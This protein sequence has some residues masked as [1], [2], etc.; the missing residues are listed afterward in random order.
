MRF[1]NPLSCLL[2]FCFAATLA[3]AKNPPRHELTPL[4]PEQSQLLSQAMVH[5]LALIATIQEHTPLVETYI[6]KTRPDPKLREVPISDTYMLNRVDFKKDFFDRNYTPRQEGKPSLL[7]Q[8][9]EAFLRASESALMTITRELHLDVNFT[10]SPLGFTE[11]MFFDPSEPNLSRYNF[12]YVR[13]EFLGSVRTVV[14]DVQP[15]N[16][17][18]GGFSGRIWIE[19]QDANIVRLNGTFAPAHEEDSSHH[20]LHFD[21]WRTNV[22][23]GVWLPAAI[24]VEET[25][26]SGGH[27]QIGLKAQ[28]HFWGFSL[29]EPAHSGESVTMTVDDAVD[30]SGDTGDVAPLEA[31]RHW[32]LQAEN[33]VVDR[34]VKAGLVAPITEGGYEQKV[35]DQIVTNLAVP[36]NLT[37]TEPVRC[38]VML[39]TTVEATTAGNTILI[40]KGALDALPNEESIASLVALELAHIELGH[41]IDTRYAFNDRLLFPDEASFQR[42]D[43]YHNDRDNEAAAKRA[44][45]YLKASM[46]AGQL[47][48]AGLFWEQLADRGSMLKNLNTPRLG[49]SLLRPD[50]TPW[51]S[52]L[53]S[54]APKIDW[55]DLA[56][57]PALPLGS[58][59][60][61]DAWDDTVRMIN[62]KRYAPMNPGEKMPLEL[63]PVYYN[64]QRQEAPIQ[65][66]GNPLPPAVDNLDPTKTRAATQ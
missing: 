51:M 26:Y 7:K 56:Q 60:R 11:M 21:S 54:T 14:F 23:P 41:H 61:V 45:D 48:N 65:Q 40:S 52:E 20:I 42:I 9:R 3:Q 31:A 64:L 12:R 39:M 10:E 63:T 33:N 4:T 50:G 53:A 1:R 30:H 6:Q 66:A 5:E 27:D 25:H 2:P 62:A 32:V 15:K 24:Y 19:D 55:D 59:L 8:G 37:F 58:W 18:A 49:D 43:M 36:S 38:R 57:T 17:H 13:R 28:T 16:P 35:L 47:G 29:Q 44:M 34:L 22:L 46:Y